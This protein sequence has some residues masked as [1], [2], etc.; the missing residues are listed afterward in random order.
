MRS[1]DQAPLSPVSRHVKRSERK[2]RQWCVRSEADRVFSRPPHHS[3]PLSSRDEASLAREDVVLTTGGESLMVGGCEHGLHTHRLAGTPRISADG[4]TNQWTT[5]ARLPVDQHFVD[6]QAS[7][8]PAEGALQ[9]IHFDQAPPGRLHLAPRECGRGRLHRAAGVAA[10]GGRRSDA[11]LR[12]GGRDRTQP[13]PCPRA[14]SDRPHLV[15]HAH[16]DR[17]AFKS[18]LADRGRQYIAPL[19]IP[20][21]TAQ[22]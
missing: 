21:L 14:R 12:R 1:A 6:R 2:Q 9:G 18:A 16:V 20:G 13:D 3:T 22:R 15:E 17:K 4:A 10:H 7:D 8:D 11:L 19:D 5:V